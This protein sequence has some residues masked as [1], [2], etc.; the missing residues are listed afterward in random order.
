LVFPA[1]GAGRAALE[2]F[3]EMLPNR[4]IKYTWYEKQAEAT[5][6]HLQVCFGDALE[7]R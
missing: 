4:G 2:L 6:T 1:L 7:I 3:L 5:V